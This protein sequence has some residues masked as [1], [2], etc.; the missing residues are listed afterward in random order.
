MAL[1]LLGSRL[2]APVFDNSI[3]AWGSLIGVVLSSLSAG[4]DLGGKLADRRPNLETLSIVVFAAGLLVLGLPTLGPPVL[5]SIMATRLDEKYSALLETWILLGPPTV[6]R[7]H[8]NRSCDQ[9]TNMDAQEAEKITAIVLISA[10][11]FLIL[12]RKK[13]L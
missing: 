11:V 9:E 8:N 12:R 3:L 4:Y 1:E 7:L 10:V 13:L 5:G 2:L 6:T